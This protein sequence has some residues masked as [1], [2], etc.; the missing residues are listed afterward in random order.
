MTDEADAASW[1]S[2]GCPRQGRR[3]ASLLLMTIGREGRVSRSVYHLAG[4]KDFKGKSGGRGRRQRRDQAHRWKWRFRCSYRQLFLTGSGLLV[5]VI[6]KLIPRITA[7]VMVSAHRS[8]ARHRIRQRRSALHWCV[9]LI[10]DVICLSVNNA[11]PRITLSLL[12][13]TSV[14][15]VL[16]LY[17][18]ESPLYKAVSDGGE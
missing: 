7:T 18:C 5:A 8:G 1:R 11:A 15:D 10:W 3:A 16:F 4:D 13:A 6:C 17:S 14:H 2:R 9:N 12:V